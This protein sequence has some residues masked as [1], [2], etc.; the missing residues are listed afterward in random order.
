LAGS[1]TQMGDLIFPAKKKK[2]E[3]L[4]GSPEELAAE[5]TDRLHRLGFC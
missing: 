1:S 4:Q 3:I 2:T 5:L